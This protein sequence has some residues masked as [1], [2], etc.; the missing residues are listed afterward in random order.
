[1]NIHHLRLR[2]FLSAGLLILLI[3][4]YSTMAIFLANGVTKTDRVSF[5][6]IP[7]EYD[8]PF[9]DVE[10]RTRGGGVI[11]KGWYIL[12]SNDAPTIIFVHGLGGNRA[13]DEAL[14]LA[15]RLRIQGFNS[16]LFDLRAHGT[17]GDGKVSGGYFEQNDVLGAFDYLKNNGTA[18]KDIGVIGFSM[19]AAAAILAISKEREIRA[20]VADTAYASVSDL[21]VQEVGRK[22]SLPNW[23]VPIFVPGTKVAA[24]LL[25]QIKLEELSPETAVNDIDYPILV[26]HGKEDTRIPVG[27]GVRVHEAAYPGSDLWLTPGVDHMD[28]FLTYPEEYT[29]RVTRYFNER[30]GRE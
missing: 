28:S 8:L 25:Y 5:D 14:D 20:L 13:G 16:L 29:S 6:H 11:L 21:I 18:P 3:T 10:F 15:S 27:H 7:E 1:M 26:V 22:T 12:A 19:G 24:R 2:I 30:L 9:T 17:S 4:L 23:I